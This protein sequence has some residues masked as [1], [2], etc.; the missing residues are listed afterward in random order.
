MCQYTSTR[1]AESVTEKSRGPY[2]RNY[3]TGSNRVAQAHLLAV[4]V[5]A[6][7]HKKL[8]SH[9]IGAIVYHKTAA[10]YPARAAAA[11]IGAELRAVIAGLVGATLEVSVLVE[12]NL[13]EAQALSSLMK[14]SFN[15]NSIQSIRYIALC[16]FVFR[17]VFSAYLVHGWFYA[18]MMKRS[19]F[20]T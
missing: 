11:Q 18:A 8:V 2:L 12:N 6:P 5:L 13:N 15:T 3:T 7:T 14:T 17:N 10:L 16:W 1:E 9:E 19:R 4:G 20:Y